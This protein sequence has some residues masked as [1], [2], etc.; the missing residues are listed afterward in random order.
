MAKYSAESIIEDEARHMGDGSNWFQRTSQSFLS[1]ISVII[2]GFLKLLG[3]LE[4][5]IS[6]LPLTIGAVALSIVTL[7]IVSSLLC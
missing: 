4:T 5:I 7:G 1:D 2:E 6:N 3:M